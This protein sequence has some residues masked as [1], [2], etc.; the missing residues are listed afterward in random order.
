M[1]LTGGLQSGEYSPP[2]PCLDFTAMSSAIS[3]FAHAVSAHTGQMLGG[4]LQLKLPTLISELSYLCKQ[5]TNLACKG[6]AKIV[7]VSGGASVSSLV[8]VLRENE[9]LTWE[10]RH[11]RSS[12][13][14]CW[15]TWSK[16]LR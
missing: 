6:L 1:A 3:L 15:K 11:C 2:A 4:N 8:L 12:G 16:G 14:L 13:L 10:E 9:C 7:E 5:D